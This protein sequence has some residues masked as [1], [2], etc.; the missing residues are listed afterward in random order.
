[1]YLFDTSICSS[2]IASD[3][4]TLAHVN[5]L[6]DSQM[7]TCVTVRGELIHMAE[8][9]QKRIDNLSL[10]HSFLNDIQIYQI[11]NDIA[12]VYGKLKADI[13]HR[14]GPKDKSKLRRTTL[15]NLGIGDNDLW[16]AATAMQHGLILASADSDYTRIQQVGLF[17]LEIW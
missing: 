6:Q 10:V 12:D 14:F 8:Q 2:I 7:A 4:A 15:S 1:M 11:D 13:F 17:A 16:I 5:L 9:S 3:P